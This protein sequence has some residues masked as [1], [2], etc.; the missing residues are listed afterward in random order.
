MTRGPTAAQIDKAIGARVRA[1]RLQRKLTQTEVGKAL[2]VTFQQI[3]KYENGKNRVSG[4]T[5]VKLCSLLNVKPEQL[6]GNGHGVFF[7]EPDVFELVMTD[8]AMVRMLVE[9]ARLSA[10]QRKSVV[11]A[12]VQM[13]RAFLSKLK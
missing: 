2:D 13:T 7:E 6:L 10:S 4:S 8:R 12:M 11:A 5:L 3:Q 9:I 1:F